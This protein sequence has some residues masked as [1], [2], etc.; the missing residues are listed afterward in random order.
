[1]SAWIIW[2]I[3]AIVLLLLEVLSQAVWSL[4][5]AIGC[6]VAMVT[7]IYFDSLAIQGIVV[8]VSA[9]ISWILFAPAIRKWEKSRG[10]GSHTGMDALIGRTAVV[11][12]DIQP[13]KMGR[14][15]IDGDYWQV[16]APEVERT[17]SI[18]ENVVVTGY[19]SIVL[20]VAIKE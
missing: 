11:T 6:L 13:G 4:C 14:A 20:N 15:R 7:S 1:M 5:F 17:I 2:L 12:E 19:E 16:Q 9:I 3:A 8:A 10:H 18:G